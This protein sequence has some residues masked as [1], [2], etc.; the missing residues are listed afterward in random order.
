MKRHRHT[1][2]QI[3]RKTARRRAHAQR[4]TRI[5]PRSSDTWRSPSR[6]L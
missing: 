5:S 1:P 3:V 6:C 2:D 4:E